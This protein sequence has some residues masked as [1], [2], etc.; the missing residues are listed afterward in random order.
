[1]CL[2]LPGK[3]VEVPD[4]KAPAGMGKVNFGGVVKEVSLACVPE[5][6]IGDYV[7]VHAGLAISTLDEKEALETLRYLNEMGELADK[8]DAAQ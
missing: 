8:E 6:K 4:E 7:V 2:A 3:V 5:A 1:M